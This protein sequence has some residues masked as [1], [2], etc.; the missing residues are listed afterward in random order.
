MEKFGAG[1]RG[2]DTKDDESSPI[3]RYSG[4]RSL[5]CAIAIPQAEWLAAQIISAKMALD[6]PVNRK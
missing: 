6:I 4:R 2:A 1:A 3:S 5:L